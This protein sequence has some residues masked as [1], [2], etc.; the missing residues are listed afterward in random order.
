MWVISGGV[1]SEPSSSLAAHGDSGPALD[2]VPGEGMYEDLG[3]VPRSI[4]RSGLCFALWWGLAPRGKRKRLWPSFMPLTRS[5]IGRIR[6]WVLS[7][8]GLGFLCSMGLL[9]ELGWCFVVPCIPCVYIRTPYADF[10]LIRITYR[11]KRHSPKV[12]MH[13]NE[14]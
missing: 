1:S 2:S 5:I 14:L 10:N 9:F 3:S 4:L 12:V 7:I 6:L 13:A 8:K 11:K